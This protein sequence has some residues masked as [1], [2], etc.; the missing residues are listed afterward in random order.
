MTKIKKKQLEKET[1]RHVHTTIF[2]KKQVK[3]FLFKD[4]HVTLNSNDV[5]SAT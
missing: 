4:H 2:V 3:N 1:N 5:L